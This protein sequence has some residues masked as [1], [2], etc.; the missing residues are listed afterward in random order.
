VTGVVLD[1]PERAGELLPLVVALAR[2]DGS[3]SLGVAAVPGEPAREE[4]ASAPGFVTRATNMALALGGEIGDPGAVELRAMSQE[5]FDSFLAFSVEDYIGE[6]TSAGMSPES[7]RRQGEQQMAELIPAGLESPGQSFFTAWVGQTS[8]G[9]L[10]LSTE[11]PLAFV[12]DI[13]VDEAQRRRGYGEAIMNAGARWCRDQGHPALGLNVFA[14][15]PGARALYDKLG[16]R[17]TADFR[18]IDLD[19]AR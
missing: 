14:H 16:Y 9:T 12:Y 7:A 15:N 2:A 5:E 11:R 6:L 17:V 1:E 13:L 18:T 19:D 4:L 10:W 8:V 3:R